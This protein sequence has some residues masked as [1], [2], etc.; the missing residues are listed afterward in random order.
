MRYSAGY[1]DIACIPTRQAYEGKRVFADFF[2]GTGVRLEPE[3]GRL[4][5]DVAL[6][7]LQ[8]APPFD[9][10][11]LNN[12][13]HE[14]AATL[15]DRARALGPA[16]A[17][18]FEVDLR[19]ASSLRDVDAIAAVAAPFG[20]KIVVSTGDPNLAHRALKRLAPRGRRYLCCVIDPGDS[21]YEWRSL[22]ALAYQERALDILEVFPSCIDL[23][24][25]EDR[26][27]RTHSQLQLDRYFPP[28]TGWWKIVSAHPS[29]GA[30]L[31]WLR[32]DRIDRLLS[33]RIG[34]PRQASMGDRAAYPLIFATRAKFAISL[35]EKIGSPPVGFQ[36][37]FYVGA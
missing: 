36:D 24:A 29:P 26:G 1:L 27:R 2:A 21:V 33:L 9:L 28:E 18:V 7:A 32:E 31:R 25:S 15:A 35:W 30:A 17:E 23:V 16:G 8:I 12:E 19:D 34:R 5:W 14:V 20:P 3:T 37:E 10:Y 22:E 13:Y 4:Y 11:F 6:L